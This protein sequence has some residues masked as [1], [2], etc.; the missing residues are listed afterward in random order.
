M[1]LSILTGAFILALLA[2]EI[3]EAEG[4]SGR[5][6]FS[7]AVVTPTCKG[8]ASLVIATTPGDT[9]RMPLDSTFCADPGME[10][11]TYTSSQRV[12]DTREQNR[13]L[14]YFVSRAQ[15]GDRA[16]DKQRPSLVTL[17]YM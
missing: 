14:H 2:S 6:S 16:G 8:A 13:L 10:A 15:S 12:L 3:V 9:S 1:H 17:T 7:G 4:T 5:L 11:T